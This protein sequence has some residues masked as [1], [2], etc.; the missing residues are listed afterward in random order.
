MMHDLLGR[1][2]QFGGEGALC[3][4]FV[5]SV[6]NMAVISQRVW[7][8]AKRHMNVA[9]FVKQ[10]APLLRV[11][12]FARARNLSQG[13]NASICAITLAGLS[14]AENGLPAVQDA[15]ETAISYERIILED[16]LVA[17]ADIGRLA[18]LIGLLGSLFDVLAFAHSSDKTS[19]DAV[20][21]A[22]P[23]H[24]AMIASV[25]PLIGGLLVA[26]PGWLAR[27]ILNVHVQRILVECQFVARLGSSQLAS[28]EQVKANSP[29]QSLKLRRVSA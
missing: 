12:D 24:A 25:S 14:E 17:L 26:I 29:V 19:P 2:A 23:I 9:K 1:L 7:F 27:S 8:F 18:L 10:L 21:I 3:A 4:L 11:R 5:L 22:Q 13:S 28:A 15:Y 20:A 6:V 16:K